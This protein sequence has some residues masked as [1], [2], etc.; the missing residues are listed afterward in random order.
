MEKSY[1]TLRTT[2]VLKLWS[3]RVCVYRDGDLYTISHSQA[4]NG[5]ATINRLIGHWGAEMKDVDRKAAETILRADGFE[6]GT[7]RPKVKLSSMRF[8][9]R[10][11]STGVLRNFGDSELSILKCLHKTIGNSTT[12]YEIIEIDHT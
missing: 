3:G 4:V 2:D 7:E 8:A 9:A 11:K 12:D 5:Q 6:L 1:L 10:H